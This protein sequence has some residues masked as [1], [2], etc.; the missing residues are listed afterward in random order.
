MNEAPVTADN[1]FTPVNSVVEL[2]TYYDALS[3]PGVANLTLLGPGE[4]SHPLVIVEQLEE[5]YLL[6]DL[7]AIRDVAPSLRRGGKF[8]LSGYTPGGLVRSNP[9][10]VR[11]F[12]SVEGRLLAYVDWPKEIHVQQRRASFRASLRLGMHV[13]VLVRSADNDKEELVE[14]QGD[15]RDLSATGCLAEFFMQDGVSRVLPD[16][17]TEIAL[18][19]PNGTSFEVTARVRH[20]KNDNDRQVM[21]V[22]FEFENPSKAQERE[23]WNYVREI[24]REAS[25]SASN[26]DSRNESEL[27][28]IRDED[29]DR[30]G[31]RHKHQY[32][33]PMARRLARIAGYLDSQMVVMRQGEAVSSQQLSLH[34][35]RLLDMLDDD[36]EEALFSVHCIHRESRWVRHGLAVA[37]RMADMLGS[38]KVPRELRKAVAASAM[39][40]DLGKGLLPQDIWRATTLSTEMYEE[41]HTH[42]DA[43]LDKMGGVKWLAPV[44]RDN[45]IAQINERLDGSGYPLG[46]KADQLGQLARMAAVVDSMDALQRSR[47][48]RPAK[49]AAV[50]AKLMQPLV[51]QFDESWLKKYVTHF[52]VLPIGSLLRFEKGVFAWVVGLDRQKRVAKVRVSPHKYA[53]DEKLGPVIAGAAL[54]EL[55]RIRDILV[56]ET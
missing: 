28:R 55:G 32:A 41:M 19:F 16:I 21:A 17:A 18:H 24:E 39:V 22:G 46:L 42:V 48:D 36:R 50:A 49:P 51:D 13:G 53:P 10:A 4:K 38:Q 8:I 52:G 47:P 6:F 26:G 54:A 3:Q 29:D 9:L 34:A 14:L 44:V 40:H 25:R 5:D 7:T 12:S 23:V 31:R 30:L 20:I 1:E 27:F 33:T 35:D 15:L 56:P 45:V 37:L 2:A 11:D 43:L